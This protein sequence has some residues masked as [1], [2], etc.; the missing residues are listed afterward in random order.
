MSPFQV[1]EIRDPEPRLRQLGA[2]HMPERDAHGM[3]VYRSAYGWIG[4]AASANGY[5]LSYYQK[6]PCS[7]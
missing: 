6:C 2:V 3:K 7:R 4:V 1:E 5:K